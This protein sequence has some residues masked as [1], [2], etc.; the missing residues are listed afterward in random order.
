MGKLSAEFE[1]TQSRP[2]REIHEIKRLKRWQEKVI[3][4]QMNS[5]SQ[6]SQQDQE[7]DI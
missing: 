7:H 2:L 3:L 6:G 1:A 5:L 4:G